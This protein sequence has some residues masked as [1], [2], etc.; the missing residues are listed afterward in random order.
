M[1]LERDKVIAKWYFS[2]DEYI[3]LL[4]LKDSF[5]LETKVIYVGSLK[6]EIDASE[7]EEVA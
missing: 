2:L 1:H 5:S 3:S 6:V 4:H 7:Q